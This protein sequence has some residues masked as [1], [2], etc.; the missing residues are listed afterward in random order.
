MAHNKKHPYLDLNKWDNA[1]A[2]WR[3]RNPG[4]L[5]GYSVDIYEERLREW[6]KRE[7]SIVGHQDNIGAK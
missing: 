3:T 4:S 2:F 5:T 1:L 7:T 6:K